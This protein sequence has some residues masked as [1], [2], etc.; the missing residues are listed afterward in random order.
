[1]KRPVPLIYVVFGLK[2]HF[3]QVKFDAVCLVVTDDI[4]HR[5]QKRTMFLPIQCTWL[6][7]TVLSIIPSTTSLQFLVRHI[8]EITLSAKESVLPM[9]GDF[10]WQMWTLW[11][12]AYCSLKGQLYIS[13]E[14][15]KKC[16]L[17]FLSKHIFYQAA[18]N[19]MLFLAVKIFNKNMSDLSIVGH[20]TSLKLPTYMRERLNKVQ[21]KAAEVSSQSR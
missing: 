4:H 12:S 2:C 11:C 18:S 6:Y 13:R 15:I 3:A 5:A 8:T 21:V 17:I 7:I 1:M 14:P 10:L 9:C 19:K 16:E 20:P